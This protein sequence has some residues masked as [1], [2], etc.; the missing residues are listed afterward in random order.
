MNINNLTG[1]QLMQ[2]IDCYE[3]TA[4]GFQDFITSCE[5]SSENALTLFNFFW[6]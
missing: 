1:R 3:K 4:K 6:S 2:V 5:V